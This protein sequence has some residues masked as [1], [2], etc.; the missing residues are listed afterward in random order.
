MRVSGV[1]DLGTLI[2]EA[3]PYLRPTRPLPE[4]EGE[5]L[6]IIAMHSPSTMASSGSPSP[7]FQQ[8]LPPIGDIQALFAA[9]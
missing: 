3:S 8:K 7:E 6:A 1:C 5:C 9:L 4:G 2:L